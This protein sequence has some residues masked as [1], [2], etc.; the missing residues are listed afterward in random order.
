M[1]V[2]KVSE[3][4]HGEIRKSSAVMSRSINAQAEFWLKMGML[5]ERNPDMTFNQI[6]LQ[7]LRQEQIDPQTLLNGETDE[8]N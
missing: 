3:E 2:L 1:G 5:C 4:L 7:Q 6:I 8:R